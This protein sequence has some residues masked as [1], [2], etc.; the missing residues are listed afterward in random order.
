MV[1]DGHINFMAQ[2][3][4]IICHGRFGI[5]LVLQSSVQNR[6]PPCELTSFL[7]WMHSLEESITLQLTDKRWDGCGGD[8][9]ARWCLESYS[10]DG[11]VVGLGNLWWGWEREG[12]GEA[13]KDLEE[14]EKIF[15]YVSIRLS[16]C[17]CFC[18]QY[19]WF[20]LTERILLMME[21]L[22]VQFSREVNLDM[23]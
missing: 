16:V 12:S 7:S 20:I 1:E 5:F 19:F 11:N 10:G 9:R 23:D 14:R 4:E 18:A 2:I 17:L 21:I 6:S 15:S 13:K 3:R 22:M 8:G